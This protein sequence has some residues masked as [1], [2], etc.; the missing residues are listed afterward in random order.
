MTVMFVRRLIAA[1]SAS[2]SSARSGKGDPAAKRT[3]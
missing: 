3:P 2:N 1:T